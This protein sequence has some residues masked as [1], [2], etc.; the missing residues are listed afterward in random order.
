MGILSA[1][2]FF[3]DWR[4][5]SIEAD[6]AKCER[7]WNYS[8]H[9]GENT[10]Y[11]DICERCTEALAE[12]EGS[13]ASPFMKFPA[14]LRWLW[15]TLAIVVVDRATKAWFETQTDAGWRHEVVH[16]F[17][18]LVHSGNPGIAFSLLPTRIRPGCAS[19]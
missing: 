7:C 11:P 3:R 15:L 5:E 9:V 2:K 6:G 10:R 1:P 12:I 13:G 17:I 8:T 16:H 19:C 14:R 4:Y 18:Y